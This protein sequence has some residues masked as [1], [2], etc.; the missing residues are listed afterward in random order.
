VSL[1][2]NLLSLFGAK[3]NMYAFSVIGKQF[4]YKT[5]KEARYMAQFNEGMTIISKIDGRKKQNDQAQQNK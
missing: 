1:S 3:L 5:L 2:K 4:K